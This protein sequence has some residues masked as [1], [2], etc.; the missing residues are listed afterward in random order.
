[1]KKVLSFSNKINTLELTY[2]NTWF[3]WARKQRIVLAMAWGDVYTQAEGGLV[4]LDNA[5]ICL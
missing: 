3:S 1:M 4:A 2:T 5:E